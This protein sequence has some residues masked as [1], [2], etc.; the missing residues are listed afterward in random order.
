MG[1]TAAMNQHHHE[2][3]GNKRTLKV[4]E[5][6]KKPQHNNECATPKGVQKSPVFPFSQQRVVPF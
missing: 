3:G 4:K 1:V 5:H 6:Q 2:R